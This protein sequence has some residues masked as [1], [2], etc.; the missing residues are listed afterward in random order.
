MKLATIAA[1]ALALLAGTVHT[2]DAH[3]GPRLVLSGPDAGIQLPDGR[4]LQTEYITFYAMHRNDDRLVVFEDGSA[5]LIDCERGIVRGPNGQ[6]HP[7]D[8]N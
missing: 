8:C 3:D 6:S 5:A 2:T 4:V 7:I 1:L